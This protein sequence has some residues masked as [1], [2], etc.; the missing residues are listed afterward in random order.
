[1]YVHTEN[2]FTRKIQI[3]QKKSVRLY[4]SSVASYCTEVISSYIHSF[5]WTRRIVGDFLCAP[6]EFR[7]KEPEII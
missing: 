3:F 7:D 4:T 6:K 1:M 2:K 5:T